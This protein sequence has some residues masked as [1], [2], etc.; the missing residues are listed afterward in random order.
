[1]DTHVY[2]SIIWNNSR[3]PAIPS[4][5]LLGMRQFSVLA[6]C[7]DD[8]APALAGKYRVSRGPHAAMLY[9]PQMRQK[10]N[11]KA[12][13]AVLSSR[14]ISV[15]GWGEDAGGVDEE[16]TWKYDQEGGSPSRPQ[17]PE[18]AVR[19]RDIMMRWRDGIETEASEF[20]GVLIP[21]AEEEAFCCL[22]DG[23][24]N[25]SARACGEAWLRGWAGGLMPLPRPP[26]KIMSSP[27]RGH[28]L[29][30]SS[31]SEVASV[32]ES[33]RGIAAT[34][35]RPDVIW[36][37]RA[38]CGALGLFSEVEKV[39]TLE[40]CIPDCGWA[41]D[42]LFTALSRCEMVSHQIQAEKHDLRFTAFNKFWHTGKIHD[43]VKIMYKE[44]LRA[45]GTN[46]GV[47]DG[48]Q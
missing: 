18:R 38:I 36:K 4:H 45:H 12:L 17:A 13:L 40:A 3:A 47:Y 19:I 32:V 11:Q 16:T 27:S 25:A 10:K 39:R 44:N 37:A 1:M 9:N 28:G 35:E 14:A 34:Y 8:I 42:L 41:D 6:P 20:E 21:R 29:V 24:A 46:S 33:L 26:F 30:R 23:F 22:E 2:G 15:E 43:T 7:L 5:L 48:I 31:T